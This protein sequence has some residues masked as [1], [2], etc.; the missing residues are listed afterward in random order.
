MFS[1]KALAERGNGQK[2]GEYYQFYFHFN[3]QSH[4]RNQKGQ[5]RF[6]DAK[7]AAWR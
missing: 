4:H 2:K 6:C 7:L 1:G 3:A 5:A